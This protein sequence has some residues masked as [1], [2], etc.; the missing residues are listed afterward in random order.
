MTYGPEAQSFYVVGGSEHY[1]GGKYLEFQAPTPSAQLT[2]VLSSAG[3]SGP[4]DNGDGAT[5]SGPGA[6]A[7]IV[8]N[9]SIYE[10]YIA[11]KTLVLALGDSIPG[12]GLSTFSW[13]PRPFTDNG[14]INYR[15]SMT[16]W[17]VSTGN[18]QNLYGGYGAVDSV[19]Y[20]KETSLIL[21]ACQG[22]VASPD[23]DN[24]P[25]YTASA[26]ANTSIGATT[27]TFNAFN[28]YSRRQH[29]M[30]NSSPWSSN[31]GSLQSMNGA[32]LGSGYSRG[33][34]AVRSDGDTGVFYMLAQ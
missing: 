5:A 25:R 1:N 31:Y 8:I 24:A 17:N 27:Q 32:G 34:A 2:F 7:S 29:G 22:G 12:Y 4:A 33:G 15:A 3:G 18:A 10:A 6:L 14:V 20:V 30:M 19:L 16:A 28:T 9:P 13:S 11:G 26:F 23:W 21:L